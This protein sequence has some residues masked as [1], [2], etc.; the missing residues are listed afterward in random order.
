MGLTWSKVQSDAFQRI[1]G[2]RLSLVGLWWVDVKM[3]SC[4]GQGESPA[5]EEGPGPMDPT[6]ALR[7]EPPLPSPAHRS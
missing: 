2:S 5:R 3:V 7:P 1:P 6:P 4:T